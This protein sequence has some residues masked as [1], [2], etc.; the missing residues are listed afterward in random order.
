[1]TISASVLGYGA[2]GSTVARSL[3]AGEVPGVELAGVV[4]RTAGRA[5]GDGFTE[6]PLDDALSVSDIVV[7]C[8]GVPAVVEFGPEIVASGTDLL[9]TSVGALEDESL[10][11]VLL[12]KGPGR[13]YLT[14]GAIGGLDLLGAAARG[15]GLDAVKLLT[16]K[17]APSLVRPW[18]NDELVQKLE[19]GTRA[20][21]VFDGSVREAI[22]LFPASLNVAVA[23]AAVTGLWDATSVEL[24]ADPDAEF[25]THTIRAHGSAG[26]YTFSIANRP[27]PGNPKTSGLVPAAV[28]HGLARL[29]TPSGT[30][31]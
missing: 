1:M 13:T 9:L 4:S 18:M 2:I 23:L 30:V 24:V 21:T 14:A 26:D 29:A 6:L 12:E 17:R 8:A 25:T 28:L 7:E 22:R 20:V 31:L 15:G 3:A 5:S 19:H 10:R 11:H 16:A 27:H